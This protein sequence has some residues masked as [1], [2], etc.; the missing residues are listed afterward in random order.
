L[1]FKTQNSHP[2]SQS[3]SKQPIEPPHLEHRFV[4]GVQV[5]T[6]GRAATV[7]RH[8]LR[9]K[10]DD[11]YIDV[12][13]EPESFHILYLEA[14][15]GTCATRK[16]R[17]L[18]K[19]VKLLLRTVSAVS[20][21][22]AQSNVGI[23]RMEG[24]SGS[25]RFIPEPSPFN[26]PISRLEKLF[27]MAGAA[28]AKVLEDETKPRVIFFSE[29]KAQKLVLESKKLYPESPNPYL[30]ASKYGIYSEDF[31]KRLKHGL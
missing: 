8:V 21:T 27:L 29:D 31:L 20:G 7:L 24:N 16:L 3:P 17:T 22:V 23:T 26:Y 4:E 11:I 14:R 13:E 2:T 12:A 19:L 25:W 30:F 18:S 15:A 10:F 5:D 6:I 9:L 1:R 28:S